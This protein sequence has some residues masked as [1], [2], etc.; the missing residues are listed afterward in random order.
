VNTDPTFW[1]GRSVFV[2]G[3]TGFKGGWL[4]LWLHQLGANI[5]G[6]A[7]N[8]PSQPNL[9]EAAS[10][11]SLLTS[12]TRANL[13]DLAKLSS[14]VDAAAPEVIFHLAA[15]PLVRE[16]YRT[17]LAT[18]MS[19]VMGTAHILE[20]ACQCDS[21][22]AIVIITTDKVYDNR[23]WIHPYR[24]VDPL[25]GLDPYSASKAAAEIVSSSYRASFFSGASGHPAQVATVRAGNVIGGGDWAHDRLVPDCL[26]AFAKGNPVHLRNPNAVRPWQHV[27][28][29]LSGYLILAQR[30]LS[31][32][33]GDFASAWNFGPDSSGNATVGDVAASIAR[34]W[35]DNA[36]VIHD[37][38][39]SNPH[40]AHMLSLDSSKARNSLRWT[41]RWTLKQ[42]LE[43]TVAWHQAWLDGNDM[44][45]VSRRQI[46]LYQ[47]AVTP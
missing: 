36:R 3:H 26:R 30:L 22:R 10:I 14:A 15:Q 28:E 11:Q 33:G 23:E 16:S 40:E 4:A 6:Y 25:G 37:F 5:H 27:L 18:L 43:N 21:V 46:D 34:L 19:N 41:P 31:P 29:P 24:E 2:T 20:A 35:G 9:F 13:S 1:N 17:P 45:S 44:K 47:A 32:D 39:D 8:P 38:S 12:D 7:L 42:A